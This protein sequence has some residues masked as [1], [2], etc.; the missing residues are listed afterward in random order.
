M[1]GWLCVC[2]LPG[3]AIEVTQWITQDGADQMACET[4][5][6]WR[7]K[8]KR[9]VCQVVPEDAAPDAADQAAAVGQIILETEGDQQ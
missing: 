2:T 9:C 7:R 4:E 1:T 8:R 6:E 5:Q 3:G